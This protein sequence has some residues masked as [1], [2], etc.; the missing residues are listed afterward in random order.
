MEGKAYGNLALDFGRL[1][2]LKKA[3]R[4]LFQGLKI[5]K[6]V[7]DKSAEGKAYG[8]VGIVFGC[9]GDLNKAIGYLNLCLIFAKELGLK[10]EEAIS[11]L[12]LARIFE[13]LGRL[14]EALE[15]YKNSVSSFNEV[16]NLL[17]G[18]D[19]WKISYRNEHNVAYTGL[20]RI[21]LR[22]SKTVEALSAAEHGRAQAL[23]DLMRSQYGVRASEIPF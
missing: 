22:Q 7:G 2:D 12:A 11:Y 18:K 3:E 9:R 16:R 21:L 15:N 23:A 5:A 8:N 19:H 13:L 14:H 4:Y 6:E 1:G 20:W 17:K 10:E